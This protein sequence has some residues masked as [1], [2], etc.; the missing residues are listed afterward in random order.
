MITLILIFRDGIRT[1]KNGKAF[2]QIRLDYLR[3][4]TQMVNG[5]SNEPLLR[6]GYRFS[7]ADHPDE[8]CNRAWTI[9]SVHH[10]GKQPQALEE[11]GGSG[12]NHLSQYF[13]TY[14][15]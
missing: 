13:C 9:V 11:A 14:S 10:Q 7:L 3:R 4:E 1:T 15:F 8:A 5:K 6:P 12:C 2:S